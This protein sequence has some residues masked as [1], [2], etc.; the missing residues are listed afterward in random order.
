MLIYCISK[1]ITCIKIFDKGM[2]CFFNKCLT[3]LHDAICIQKWLIW[4]HALLLLFDS[5]MV[6]P[7]GSKYV[8]FFCHHMSLMDF[9]FSPPGCG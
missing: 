7:C 3:Y 2:T 5:L 9:V 6:G 4:F 8:G 1:S